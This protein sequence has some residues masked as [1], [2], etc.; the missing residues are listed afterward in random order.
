MIR[1]AVPIL[2]MLAVVAWLATHSIAQDWHAIVTAGLWVRR[3][4]AGLAH[5]A[6]GHRG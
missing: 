3:V 6:L 1:R 4:G 2:I 5:A